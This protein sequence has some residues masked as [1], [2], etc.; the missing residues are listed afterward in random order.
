MIFGN[1]DSGAGAGFVCEFQSDDT[2]DI[3][4]YNGGYL[5]RRKTSQV[6]RDPS[7]WYHIVISYDSTNATSADRLRLYVNGDRVTTFST[8]TDPTLNAWGRFNNADE[9]SIGRSGA[10]NLLYLN[11][12][13]AEVHFVEGQALEAT[14]FGEYDNNNNWNPKEY[15][16]SYYTAVSDAEGALP[17]HNTTDAFGETKGSGNRTDSFAR[18]EER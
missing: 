15:S 1:L 4:D 8:S 16:G 13:V 11:A 6:F 7:A 17:I 10:Y 12:Y 14:D 2:L 3:Y 9:T 18:K 5:A